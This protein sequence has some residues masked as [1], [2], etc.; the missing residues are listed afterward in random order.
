VPNILSVKNLNYYYQDGDTRRFILRD[1]SYEFE[2]GRF[3]TI[4]GESGSG[5]TTFLSMIAALDTPKSGE[6]LFEGVDIRR[7]GYENYRRNKA[8]IVFQ[9]YNL[10]LYMTA[11][12]NVLVAMNITQ[13]ELPKDKKATAYNLLQYVGI[14]RA[15]ADRTVNKLSGGEQQRVAI[16][17]AV[18]TDVDLLL[19]DEPTGNLDEETEA[20]I[21]EV[22]KS[23]AHDY[24]K[25]VIVVTHSSEIA[26]QADEVIRL[27][28]GVFLNNGQFSG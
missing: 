14:D 4:L 3:Y 26:A 21:V 12:E 24:K 5:K 13:N 25:C 28:K 19:A 22:L 9:S 16:A 10:I 17:R 6:I 11:V 20:G 2:R 18:A 1:V 15:K 27:K 7:I 8:G 23:L